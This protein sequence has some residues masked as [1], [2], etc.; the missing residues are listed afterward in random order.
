MAKGKKCRCSHGILSF[1]SSAGYRLRNCCMSCDFLF[2]LPYTAYRFMIVSWRRPR[3]GDKVTID[4]T[5]D[6]TTGITEIWCVLRFYLHHHSMFIERTKHIEHARKQRSWLNPSVSA[7][8]IFIIFLT[9]LEANL[10][11][12]RSDH[13]IWLRSHRFNVPP[14]STTKWEYLMYRYRSS[15]NMVLPVSHPFPRL[16]D[17]LFHWYKLHSYRTCYCTRL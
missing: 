17:I 11:G 4:M 3:L 13:S 9:H 16:H 10:E 14:P 7:R 2:Y 15:N 12:N 6:M 8:G 1:S 5:I